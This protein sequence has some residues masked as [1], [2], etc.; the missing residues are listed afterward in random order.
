MIDSS[1]VFENIKKILAENNINYQLISHSAVFTS[2]QAAEI[3]KVPLD[4]G[5]KAIIFMAD[6][7]PVLIVVPAD[8]KV[9][10]KTFKKI[11]QVKNLSLADPEVIKKLT[12][13]EIGAIPPFGD[14][15]NLQSYL[16]KKLTKKNKIHFNPGVH[17]VSIT[18]DPK[19]LVKLTNPTIGSYSV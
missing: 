8:K 14:L 17:T 5:A 13:L 1:L 10:T 9:D 11:Y 15:M 18:M 12:G 16:D 6:K 3:R 19:D 7:K 2:N 4:Q